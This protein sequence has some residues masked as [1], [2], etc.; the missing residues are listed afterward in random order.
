MTTKYIT[1]GAT[2]CTIKTQ[3]PEGWPTDGTWTVTIGNK[4]GTDLVDSGAVT[5]YAGDTL[6]AA[7]AAGAQ[8]IVLTTG[9][10]LVDGDLIVI[11]SDAQGWQQRE[12]SKYV[13]GTKTATLRTRLDEAVASGSEVRGLDL[14]VVVD[15]SGWD[16]SVVQVAVYWE[17]DGYPDFQELYDVRAKRSGVAGLENYFRI[18][19]PA[20]HAEIPPG[21]FKELESMAREALKELFTTKGRNFDLIVDSELGREITILEIATIVGLGAGMSEAE[22]DRLMSRKQYVMDVIDDLDIWIDD[23]EDEVEDDDEVEPAMQ[24]NFMRGMF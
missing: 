18:Y 17:V 4:A 8:D 12:V 19:F 6:S 7:A 9:T 20:L 3:I 22:W 14:S 23:N 10:A 5:K 2:A 1:Y 11:G 21:D 15:A 16:D 13:A 24:R